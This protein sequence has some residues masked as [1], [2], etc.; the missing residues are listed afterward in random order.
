MLFLGC[1]EITRGT[2]MVA[3]LAQITEM[4]ELERH[5]TEIKCTVSLD[6]RNRIEEL[7]ENGRFPT[8][9]DV[10][11]IALK[12]LIHKAEGGPYA[13]PET[14]CEIMQVADAFRAKM[15]KD[16]RHKRRKA[17][18]KCT[19]SLDTRDRIEKLVEKG[20]FP[21]ISDAVEIALEELIHKIE[22]GP[23]AMPETRCEIMQVADAFRAK[24]RRGLLWKN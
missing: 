20:R 2:E 4:T 1:T 16:I 3:V 22:G 24:I 11:E 19:V 5:N 6:T 17:E 14:R 21:T 12:E 15:R 13:M 8:I 23:Y 9:S 7:V 18:I 10:V